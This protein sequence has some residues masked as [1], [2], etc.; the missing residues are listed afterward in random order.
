M[1]FRSASI[2]VIGA[3]NISLTVANEGYDF[4][5]LRFLAPK[6]YKDD[7]VIAFSENLGCGACIRGG[8]NFCINGDGS[9]KICCKDNTCA[10]AKDATYVCSKTYSDATVA[11][12]ICPFVAAK[13]GGSDSFSFT[14]VGE[15]QNIT[16]QLKAGE[17]CTYIVQADCGLPSFKP[18]DTSGFEIE[19]VD[20][21][22]D[23]LGGVPVT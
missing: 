17:T 5:N 16:L 21:D 22:D 2:L 23:D 6:V 20:Y 11:K 4:S 1:K 9:K 18:N 19:N 7:L 14:K 12:N 13:C 10:T 15:S 8:Y 3:I